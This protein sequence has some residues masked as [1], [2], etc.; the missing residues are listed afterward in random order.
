LDRACHKVSNPTQISACWL[1]SFVMITVHTLTWLEKQNKGYIIYTN[2]GT[3]NIK[4]ESKFWCKIWNSDLLTFSKDVVG[5]F[6]LSNL[7]SKVSSANI[8]LGTI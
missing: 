1:N 4:E 8:L 6:Y 5:F 7:V 2:S 3:L